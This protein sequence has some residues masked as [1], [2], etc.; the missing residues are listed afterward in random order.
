MASD[1]TK[2]CR[3]YRVVH[4]I[5]ETESSYVDSLVALR[6]V[7]YRPLQVQKSP[8]LR[9]GLVAMFFS[10]VLQILAL[11][12]KLEEDLKKRLSSWGGDGSRPSREEKIGSI[13]LKYAPLFQ[14]YCEYAN[15][16]NDA[17]QRIAAHTKR[18]NKLRDF[19]AKAALRD[20]RCKHRSLDAFLIMPIQRVPRYALLLQDLGKALPEH[21][22]SRAEVEEALH[23]SSVQHCGSTAVCDRS[24]N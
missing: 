2:W 19:L 6:E 16:F 9:D 12:Q 1:E 13:F 18:S 21:H 11:N 7:F 24:R 17:S 4:E 20:S 10:N 23:R 15:A 8:L 22:N 14:L 3:H 5:V